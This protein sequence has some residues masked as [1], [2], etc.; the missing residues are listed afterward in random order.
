MEWEPE[1]QQETTGENEFSSRMVRTGRKRIRH[2]C[3]TNDNKN[4]SQNKNKSNSKNKNKNKN[5]KNNKK[6]HSLTRKLNYCYHTSEKKREGS[7]RFCKEGEEEEEEE[8]D[9]K[10]WSEQQSTRWRTGRPNQHR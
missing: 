4:K 2:K 8:V 1:G 7:A 5:N 10:V 3:S 9:T 6:T